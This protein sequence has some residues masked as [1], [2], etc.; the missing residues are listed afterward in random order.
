MPTSQNGYTANDRSIITSI[1]VPGGRLSCRED[2][3]IPD[4]FDYVATR[5]HSEVERLIWPGCWGYAER[6]IRGSSTT[7]S[8]HASGTAID[9]N[10]P[11]H[12]LGTSIRA[13]YSRKQIRRI[14]KIVRDCDGVIRWGGDYSGRPDGM[15]FEINDTPAAC[16]KLARKIKGG[17]ATNRTGDD[18]PTPKDLWTWDKVKVPVNVAS[19]AYRRINPNWQPVRVLSEILMRAES[20]RHHSKTTHQKVNRMQSQL[21][22]I[23]QK[24]DGK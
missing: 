16:R 5:Y 14:R 15:H 2:Y 12:P 17:N 20:G 3:G 8:N 22:R 11:A 4:V 7:L 10:A 21:D 1:K 9:L 18:M 23:E 13:N 6:P 24:L 19:K